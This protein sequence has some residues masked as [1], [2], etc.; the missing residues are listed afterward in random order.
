MHARSFGATRVQ[1]PVIGQGTWHIDRSDRGDAIAALRAGIDAGMTHIDTA[2]MY[3]DAEA[4]VAEAIVDCREE[5][6]LVSKV[7]PGNAT[8]RGVARAC[9][10]SLRRLRTDRLDSYLLHW[11]GQH[12]LEETIAGFEDLRRAG[13]ILSWGV[14]NFDV[15]DLDR[16]LAIAGPDRIA[17]N[18]VL[19]H[20]NERAI[21]HAVLP[22]CEKN[23]VALIGYSPFG[24]GDFPD[25]ASPGGQALAGIAGT[26]G[27]TPH[28]VALA[29]LTRMTGTF[30][31]P[32]TGRRA[33]AI[34]NAGAADL[35]L[36]PAEI[37]SLD[38]H[39]P[40]GPRPRML[41]ML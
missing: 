1:V 4:I 40:R 31:I 5:V 19:Y 27:T 3:G 7:V 17:C 26:H 21:E 38:A 37:A 30:T 9:E 22:W 36:T 14:S 12:P 28:A 39:F 32:K 10:D 23:G 35:R 25:P 15:A 20:L 11:P 13:K 2:E 8:R 29:F 16:A 34:E 41:P 6:F 33:R 18:Q 24:S